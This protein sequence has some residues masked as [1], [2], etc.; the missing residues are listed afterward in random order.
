MENKKKRR[1]MLAVL[2]GLV[3]TVCG[4]ALTLTVGG[5]LEYILPAPAATQ[6]G[7]E[8]NALYEEA[9]KQMASIADSITA[10]AVGARAQGV[11]L[12]AE[13]QSAEA[14]VYAVGSGYF[15]VTHETLLDG[16]LIS[17]A[18]VK[19][20]ENVVVIDERMALS[21]FAGNEPVGQTVTLSGLDYEV[22]GVIKAE[23][24]LGETN[25]HIA[26]I[27]ITSASANA[28]AMQTVEMIAKTADKTTGSAILM[29][30]TLKTWQPGGSFYNYDK[31][32]LGAV[33][34]IRW[35]VLFVGVALLL[36]LLAR[37]NAAAWG[38]VCLYAD[39]LKTRY[40]RDM[41]AGMIASAL[42][43]LLGYAALAGAA[44]ALAKFSIDPLYVFTEWVPEVLVELSS[45]AKR[46]WSL[47][48]ANAAAVRYVSRSFCVLETGRALLRWGLLALLLGAWMN[49]LPFFSRR[50]KMPEINRLRLRAPQTVGA[51]DV[52]QLLFAGEAELAQNPCLLVGDGLAG[53]MKADV[54]AQ[55]VAQNAPLRVG[56]RREQRGADQMRLR[57]DALRGFANHRDE[58]GKI[59][60]E[61]IG[62]GEGICAG[63]DHRFKILARG[64]DDD[65]RVGLQANLPGSLRAVYRRMGE[66]Q[67]HQYN[68]RLFHE[69][70]LHRA[71]SVCAVRAKL[72]IR[73]AAERLFDQ[74]AIIEVILDQHDADGAHG[75]RLPCA[76]SGKIRV[77]VQPFPGALLTRMLPSCTFITFWQ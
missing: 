6:E 66:T 73:L 59:A 65:A 28:L 61:E 71:F 47:N 1:G 55:K 34:P 45:I 14:T 38:R 75:L 7:G 67:I 2:L 60:L 25:E 32:A 42:L 56:Q 53:G 31:L 18:D 29:E 16:R 22:A 57:G 5:R 54:F 62:R 4:G 19:R 15:D 30:N 58:H 3:L 40:A 27:P 72:E 13:A 63:E 8:L 70:G 21:F 76:A 51:E 17:E 52:R 24:R 11:N 43:M 41:L 20:A 46:F 10:G 36:S 44:F 68:I 35:A 23:R 77:K 48:D 50:V 12:S 26:Y 49:G 37:L 33:M 39:R 74:I 9:Q 69:R 64:E